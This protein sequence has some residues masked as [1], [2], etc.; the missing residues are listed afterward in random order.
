[1]PPKLTAVT[2]LKFVP[3]MVTNVPT[4]PEEGVNELIVGAGVE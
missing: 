1:M 2:T 4:L 3:V